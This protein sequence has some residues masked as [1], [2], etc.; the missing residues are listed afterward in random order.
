[1]SQEFTADQRTFQTFNPAH[2]FA[3]LSGDLTDANRQAPLAL[4]IEALHSHRIPD[5]SVIAITIAYSL[6]ATLVGLWRWPE[7]AEAIE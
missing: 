5:R 3:I 7:K 2:K 6:A 1:M 4:W